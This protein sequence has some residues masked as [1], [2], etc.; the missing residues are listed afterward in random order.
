MDRNDST[1]R[2]PIKNSSFLTYG[3]ICM[4]VC[5]FNRAAVSPWRR[6]AG[7][8]TSEGKPGQPYGTLPSTE[9]PAEVRW[10]R[11][12]PT[13]PQHPPHAVPRRALEASVAPCMS[14]HSVKGKVLLAE[15]FLADI[16]IFAMVMPL[17]GHLSSR[18]L[19]VPGT[20]WQ[21]VLQGAVGAPGFSLSHML[22]WSH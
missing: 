5:I 14:P 4:C 18:Y 6:C 19:M 10:G 22:L 16:E 2:R 7:V 1:A 11:T 17:V 8:V 9:G 3:C 13:V 21:W 20:R 12:S 15:R